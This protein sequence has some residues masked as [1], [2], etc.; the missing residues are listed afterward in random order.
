MIVLIIAIIVILL[1][2]FPI[3]VKAK[4]I[5][6]FLTNKGFVSLFLFGFNAF[7]GKIKILPTKL[8]LLS[9]KKLSYLY[10]FKNNTQE[11]FSEMF[12]SNL[13]R[14]VRLNDLR[15]IGKFGLFT[16]CLLTSL[17]CGGVMMGGG[18][19]YSLLNSFR[20]RVPSSIKIFPDYRGNTLLLC[21]T[22]SIKLNLFVILK[23]FIQTICDFIK[24]SKKNGNKKAD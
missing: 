13:L 14:N 15:F 24:R 18:I 23:T 9:K 3:K 4:V 10:F 19:V 6:N 20:G 5:F 17:S 12:Y 16:N 1:L 22:S 11:D 7:L 2:F 21:F 8:A